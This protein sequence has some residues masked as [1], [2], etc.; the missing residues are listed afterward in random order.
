METSKKRDN[1]LD[2]EA[3]TDVNVLGLTAQDLRDPGA[4]VSLRALDVLITCK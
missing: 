2:T 1:S 4:I 3:D